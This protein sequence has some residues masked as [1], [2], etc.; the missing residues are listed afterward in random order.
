MCKLYEK[1]GQ[2]DL[3]K[4]VIFLKSCKHFIKEL[5]LGNSYRFCLASFTESGILS[6]FPLIYNGNKLLV[7]HLKTLC[8]DILLCKLLRGL[9]LSYL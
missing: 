8:Q 6:L 7:N 1:N 2:K 5:V 3:Q 4:L 9:Y